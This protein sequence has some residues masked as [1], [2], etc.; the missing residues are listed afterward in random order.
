MEEVQEDVDE[1]KVRGRVLLFSY[2]RDP[3]DCPSLWE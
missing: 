1:E 2:W 3:V